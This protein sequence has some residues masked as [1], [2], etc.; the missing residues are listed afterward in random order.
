VEA[1]DVLSAGATGIVVGFFRGE[2]TGADKSSDGKARLF[3]GEITGVATMGSSD[4]ETSVAVCDDDAAAVITVCLFER[5]TVGDDSDRSVGVL[6]F[7]SR[8]V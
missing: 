8:E 4:G 6:F 3:D 1:P 5:D 7:L 2:E